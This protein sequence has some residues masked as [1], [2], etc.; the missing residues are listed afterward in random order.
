MGTEIVSRKSTLAC[1]GAWNNELLYKHVSQIFRR[2]QPLI[3]IFCL[4]FPTGLMVFSTKS[5]LRKFCVGESD[6]WVCP[7][8]EEEKKLM[9]KM[10]LSVCSFLQKVK[11]YRDTMIL[12]TDGRR[13]MEERGSRHSLIIRKVQH[14]DFGNYSCEAYNKLGR[15]SK[16]IELSGKVD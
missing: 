11:W 12:D 8:R 14:S 1:F 10:C 16:H 7:W 13:L 2:T 15:S 3:L 4:C 6:M 9:E 5:F